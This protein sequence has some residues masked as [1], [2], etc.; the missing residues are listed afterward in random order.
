MK[1]IIAFTILACLILSG[2]ASSATRFSL[3]PGE[4]VYSFT[5]S[6]NKN[7]KTA[8][9]L[10]EE[11]L[12]QNIKDANKVIT[13]RQPE[14]GVLVANPVMQVPVT[15]VSYVCDYTLRISCTDNQVVAKYTVGKLENGTYPPKDSMVY[16][17]GY[18]KELTEGMAIY[19]NSN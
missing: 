7:Q 10:A 4:G 13:L 19:I 9:Y 18:F 6:T 15:I 2:C 16:I 14:T 3:D 5:Q 12:S 1:A 17:H 11:W 8:Y